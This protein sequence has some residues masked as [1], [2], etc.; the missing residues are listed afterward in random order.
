MKTT[1]KKAQ[2]KIQQMSFMIVAVFLFL[3]M[4]GMVVLTLKLSETRSDATKLQ[5]QNA[6]LLASKI[7]NSPEFSCE[8]AYYDTEKQ[9]SK[10]YLERK[11]FLGGYQYRNKENLSCNHPLS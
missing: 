7:A 10:I 3:S 2:M 11:Q 4:V 9:H 8:N 5:E 6:M 1:N